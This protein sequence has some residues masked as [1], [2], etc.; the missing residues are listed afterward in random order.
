MGETV[1]LSSLDMRFESYRLRD[2]AREARLLASIAERGIEQPLEGVDTRQ[3]ILLSDGF[4]RWRC[5]NKLSVQ[6]VP[7]VSLGTDEAQAAGEIRGRALE[8]P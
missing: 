7:Y 1:E 4:K 8:R 5:A 3:G 2:K 6:R